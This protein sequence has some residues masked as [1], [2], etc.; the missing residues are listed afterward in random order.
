MTHQPAIPSETPMR[1]LTSAPTRKVT[2]A[3]VA[4]AISIVVVWLLNTY[5]LQANPI[6]AEVASAIT[7][8]V[9]FV[10]G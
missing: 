2:A 6:P 9:G 5:V 3:T 10:I 7:T 4:G 1:T 8:I